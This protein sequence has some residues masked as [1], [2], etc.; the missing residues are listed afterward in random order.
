MDINNKKNE[1]KVLTP[2][3]KKENKRISKRTASIQRTI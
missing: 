2:E 3:D 1:T